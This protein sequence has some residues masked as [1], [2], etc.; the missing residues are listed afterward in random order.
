MSELTLAVIR[1]GLL[2]LLWIFVFSVVGV[3]R[4]D[5]YGTRVLSRRK[6]KPQTRPAREPAAK[7]VPVATA[8]VP[9]APAPVPKPSRASGR[10]V[11]TTLTVTEGTLAGTTLTLMDNGVLL[12][13]NPECT[14]VLDD[15]FASGRHARIFR[16]DGSWFV[17]D[18][19]STNGTYL[20]S[21]KL[22]APMPVEVGSTLRIGKTVFELRK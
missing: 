20:A 8:A 7:P 11:P 18:L 13:R 9:S 14:L 1:L 16:R 2:A 5:L 10:R 4:G 17:E 21:R 12:G 15:D 22:T 19:G 6:S 3:L